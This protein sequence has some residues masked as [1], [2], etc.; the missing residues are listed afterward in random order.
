MAEV[1]CVVSR[2]SRGSE[3]F[4]FDFVRTLNMNTDYEKHH[5]QDNLQER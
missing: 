1:N 3:M 5:K 4:G 2:T